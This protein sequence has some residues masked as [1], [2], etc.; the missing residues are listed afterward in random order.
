MDYGEA[1]KRVNRM[2]PKLAVPAHYVVFCPKSGII[3]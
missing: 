3:Y 1:A 2:K